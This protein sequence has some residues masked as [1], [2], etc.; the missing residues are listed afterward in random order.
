MNREAPALND[1]P[2]PASPS[3]SAGLRTAILL[4]VSVLLL[5]LGGLGYLA[6]NARGEITAMATANSDNSQWS[7][8]QIE[9][10][11]ANLELALTAPPAA[12]VTARD[13]RQKFDILFSRLNIL[14]NSPVF[15]PVR[16]QPGYNRQIADIAAWLDRTVAIIDGP[17]EGLLLAAPRLADEMR[18]LRASIRTLSTTGVRV[19]AREAQTLREEVMFTLGKL[20]ALTAIVLVLLAVGWITLI[21]LS[22]LRRKQSQQLQSTATRLTAIIGTSL[23]A[24]VVA[25]EQGRFVDFNGAAEQVFG[26]SRDEVLGQ[27]MGDMI[28]P[29][30]MRGAHGAGMER[31]RKTGVPHV[32][33]KGRVRLEAMRKSGEIFPVEMSISAVMQDGSPLFVSYIRDISARVKAEEALVEARDKALAGERAKAELLAVMSHE[34]R[35]PLNG[36]L[37]TLELLG[38]TRLTA[39]Q[40]AYLSVLGTS[41]QLLLAQV[42]DVLDISRHDAGQMN[43]ANEPLDAIGLARDVTTALQPG[44]EARGNTLSLTSLS[45]DTLWARGDAR[46]VRQVLMNIVGNAIKFTRDGAI[47][48]EVEQVQDDGRWIELRV[49]DTGV[50][51][52]AEDLERIFDDFVT[53]DPGYNR[54]AEGTGLGLGITRRLVAAM[55]G[56]IGVESEPGEGSLFWVRL[57]FDAVEQPTPRTAHRKK[58]AGAQGKHGLG[59]LLIED[60]EINRLVV[61]DMLTGMGHRVS[62]AHDGRQGVAMAAR[63]HFDVIL[64]DISMPELDGIE[65]TRLIRS[66]DGRSRSTPIVAL[67]AHALPDDIERF[68]AAG[69]DDV[70][71]K[72]I[73][74]DRLAAAL[75]P[76]DTGRAPSRQTPPPTA[77]I[78][79]TLDMSVVQDARQAFGTER[80]SKTIAT[81]LAETASELDALDAMIHRGEGCGAEFA[82]R[83]HKISGSAAILGAHQLHHALKSVE[84]AARQGDAPRVTALWPDVPTALTASRTAFDAL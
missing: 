76:L 69:M 84:T 78:G 39:K 27:A 66:G 57:P 6:L 5:T 79:G 45:G 36:V 42:N 75:T 7:L 16:A 48:V 29:P 65:V 2:Q 51:I 9:V 15:E 62:E 47:S 23:D 31:Y 64:T 71:T 41:S 14:Q 21:R 68:R 35:T 43:M 4:G 22:L 18:A 33:G 34:M 37:G 12:P 46:R 20:A 24:I 82:A 58:D 19:F 32:V 25:D 26:Y 61:R 56:S 28:V 67:T 63:Q 59:I 13:I 11:A 40:R 52:A 60:N 44:A 8:A 53:L 70:L 3:Q 80:F 1:S 30:A 38:D 49:A 73:S 54:S 74:R 77:G 10:D 17:D 83:V 72:P 50:G 55:G 81:F